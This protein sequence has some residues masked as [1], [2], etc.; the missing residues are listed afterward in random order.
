MDA[1][2]LSGVCGQCGSPLAQA[3]VREV[4]HYEETRL[5]QV[6]CVACE[7]SFFAVATDKPSRDSI[8]IE[9]VAFAARALDRARS[10]SQLF[11]LG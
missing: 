9:E 5:M 11:D 8:S 1:S 4:R 3:L 6:T 2:S 7:R 10:L